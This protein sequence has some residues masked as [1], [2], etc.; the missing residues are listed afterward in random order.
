MRG[1]GPKYSAKSVFVDPEPWQELVDRG[2]NMSE[3]V[4]NA[5]TQALDTLKRAERDSITNSPV[6]ASRRR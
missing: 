4:R 5:V 6:K 3:L 2:V 1:K